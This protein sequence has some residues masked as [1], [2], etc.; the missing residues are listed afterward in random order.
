MEAVMVMVGPHPLTRSPTVRNYE[1][2]A[3]FVL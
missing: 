2:Q 1:K 3:Q